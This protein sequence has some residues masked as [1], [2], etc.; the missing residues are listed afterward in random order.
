MID[1]SLFEMASFIFNKIKKCMILC[2][3]LLLVISV[4]AISGFQ[5]RCF[6]SDKV[7][8]SISIGREGEAIFGFWF[9]SAL[10]RLR[11]GIRL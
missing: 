11:L 1:F 6:G 5:N 3:I 4:F 8:Q 10:T 2:V 9:I 7:V